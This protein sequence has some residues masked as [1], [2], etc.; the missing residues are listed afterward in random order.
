MNKFKDYDPSEDPSS[1]NKVM[2]FVWEIVKVVVVSVI[3]I[4]PIRMFVVQPFIVEGASME[5]T[6]ENGE[7]LVVDEIS[8]RFSDIKRGDVVIFH[9]P[10]NASLYYIKRVI[11]LPGEAVEI[12]DGGIYI[13]N[14]EFPEGTRLDEN[15]YLPESALSGNKQKVYLKDKEYFVAGDNRGNSLDSRS[16]GPIVLERIKGKVFLRAFPFNRLDLFKAPSYNF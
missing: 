11:G 12:K 15:N 13:Y 7:Y 16:F 14:D 2:R 10:H 5:P 1:F 6:F 3:I 8:L 9:P 4:V